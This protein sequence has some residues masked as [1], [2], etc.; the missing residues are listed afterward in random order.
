M[1]NNEKFNNEQIARLEMVLEGKTGLTKPQQ[2]E[3]M[4]RNLLNCD[5]ELPEKAKELLNTLNDLY[6]CVTNMAT[7]LVCENNNYIVYEE[8]K[9]D[10]Y[11]TK[12]N[13]EL[14]KQLDKAHATNVRKGIIYAT[15]NKNMYN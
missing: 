1:T 10:E 8:S 9:E 5:Y 3:L 14:A 11:C 2:F 4:V 13:A 15:T 12:I 7:K 6:E